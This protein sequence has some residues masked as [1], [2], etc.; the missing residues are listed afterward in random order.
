MPEEHK[1]GRRARY[2]VVIE[3]RDSHEIEGELHSSEVL[4]DGVLEELPDEAG[5]GW[6]LDY[7]EQSDGLEGSRAAL[8]V[9]NR[10]VSLSREGEHPLEI[11]LEQGVRHSCYYSTPAGLMRLGVFAR[12]VETNLNYSGGRIKLN[13]TLDFYADLMS[14]NQMEIKVQRSNV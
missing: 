6:Q 5:G 10:L 14:S 11:T 3:I 1:T 4:C 2:P 7:I 8:R 12:S 13:Y 9:Q